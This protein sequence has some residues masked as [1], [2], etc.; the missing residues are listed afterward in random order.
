VTARLQNARL[1]QQLTRF[2]LV[3]V[4]NTVISLVSYAVMISV[5]V[6]YALAGAIAFVLGAANG[7]VLN[8]RWTFDARDNHATR[9][10]YAAIQLGGLGTTTALLWLLVSVGRADRFAAYAMTVPTVTLLAFLANRGW[11][12]TS[13]RG[14]GPG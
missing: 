5:G 1:V 12:F 3:G 10:K 2:L 8:Q 6:F 11:V 9:V 4:S 7:Y 13:V 14:N